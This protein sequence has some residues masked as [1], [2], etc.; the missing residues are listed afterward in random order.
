MAKVRR[1]HRD[2]LPGGPEDPQR[3]QH[4]EANRAW[5]RRPASGVPRSSGGMSTRRWRSA[6]PSSNR[7]SRSLPIS[8][9]PYQ[10]LVSDAGAL[11]SNAASAPPV[12]ASSRIAV[13]PARD[14]AR[15]SGGRLRVQKAGAST[16]TVTSAASSCRGRNSVERRIAAKLAAAARARRTSAARRIHNASPMREVVTARQ[17]AASHGSPPLSTATRVG[18]PRTPNPRPNPAATRR[19]RRRW[20]SAGASSRPPKAARSSP[21][22]ATPTSVAWP[23]ARG[24]TTRASARLGSG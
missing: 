2:A 20:L 22:P 12:T 10:A 9:Q 4:L 17:V 3:N 24:R 13:A 1:M 21:S 18:R 6:R 14:H 5:N 15:T 23:G 19:Q 16:G 8:A 11:S 7:T